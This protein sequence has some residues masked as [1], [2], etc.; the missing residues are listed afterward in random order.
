MSKPSLAVGRI[1][2]NAREGVF[3]FAVKQDALDIKF[4]IS[5]EAVDDKRSR[6]IGD[7]VISVLKMVREY[8]LA[9]D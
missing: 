1:T 3:T 8:V 6:E 4:V 2:Y 5:D 9:K 7:T